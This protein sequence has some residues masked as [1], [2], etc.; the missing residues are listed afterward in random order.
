MCASVIAKLQ[1]SGVANTVILSVVE[2]MEECLN[3]IH[4]SIKR[5]VL[6]VVPEGNPSRSAV[7]EVL[8]NLENPFAD[9][10]TDSK[11][12]KYFYS[13]WGV[14]QPVEVHLGVRY[15]SKINRISGNYEQ[16]PVNDTF[17]YVPLFKTLEFIFKN[18]M[19]C[20]HIPSSNF[21]D[22]Y[23]DFCDGSYFK[24][25]QL[26]SSC[27]HAL[28]IQVYYDDFETANPI[29]SKAGLHK[30]GCL[31]FTLRNLPPPSQFIFDEYTSNVFVPLTRC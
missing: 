22:L 11:W 16:V 5:Q 23:S 27:P 9:L 21:S 8:E 7:E 31:Y 12:K 2:S 1:G 14:V 3:D 30:L 6:E 25:N 20:S 15:D 4:T 24:S 28:Q 18:K 13:K 19:I 29:G 26:F 17:I 10:N